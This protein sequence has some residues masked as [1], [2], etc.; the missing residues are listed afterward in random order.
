M[1]SRRTVVAVMCLIGIALVSCGK[2]VVYSEVKT[3]PK[4]GWNA[5]SLLTYDVTIEDTAACYDVLL[6][7]RHTQQYPYQNMWLFVGQ[8]T[9]EFYLADQRGRWLG[10]GWG[11][12]REMPVI[13]Q[14]NKRF[15]GGGKCRYTIQQAMRDTL[16]RGV[17]DVGLT[18]VRSDGKE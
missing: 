5:D 15:A 16:L 9:I 7:V 13:Y 8:D 4:E 14:H 3:L 1:G 12:L 2:R 10:N 17:Q 11:E 6:Y 18:I